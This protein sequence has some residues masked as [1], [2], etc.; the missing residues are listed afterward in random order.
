MISSVSHTSSSSTVGANSFGCL[1]RSTGDLNFS[2]SRSLRHT[3]YDANGLLSFARGTGEKMV[4]R[5]DGENE[6]IVHSENTCLQ[7]PDAGIFL[8]CCFAFADSNWNSC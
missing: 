1:R 2:R 7:L 6:G 3:V 5:Y 8:S 4:H